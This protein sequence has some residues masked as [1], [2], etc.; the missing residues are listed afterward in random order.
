MVA[1]PSQELNTLNVF[2]PLTVNFR[3]RNRFT[4]SN[5]PTEQDAKVCGDLQ[6][7]N[8]LV[9]GIYLNAGELYRFH[10]KS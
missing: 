4:C 10:T 2:A 7:Q 5:R 9:T 6:D 1:L 8:H 3:I